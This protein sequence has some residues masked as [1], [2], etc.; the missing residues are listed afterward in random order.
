MKKK[1]KIIAMLAIISIVLTACYEQETYTSVRG[2]KNGETNNT[3]EN[4]P[5]DTE[6]TTQ[7]S[8]N[9]QETENGDI[10]REVL[11]V[12]VDSLNVRQNPGQNEPL[13]TSLIRDT[14]VEVIEEVQYNGESWT[15]IKFINGE[16]YVLTEYLN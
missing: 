15:H 13:V 11:R 7:D 12:N 16:G 9:T 5:T 8:N 6:N 1:F 10:E 4:T 2:Q 3:V 14:E